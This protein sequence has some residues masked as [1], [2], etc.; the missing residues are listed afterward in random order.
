MAALQYGDS[1]AIWLT[2]FLARHKYSPLRRK[3]TLNNSAGQSSTTSSFIDLLLCKNLHLR[4]GG[5]M[6]NL[7]SSILNVYK[8]EQEFG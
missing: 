7:L 5:A 4:G 2:N 6:F 1:T 3:G 8:K